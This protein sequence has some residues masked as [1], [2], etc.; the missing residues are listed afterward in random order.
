MLNDRLYALKD[1]Y[2]Q[3]LVDEIYLNIKMTKEEEAEENLLFNS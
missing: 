1:L 3:K 2:N